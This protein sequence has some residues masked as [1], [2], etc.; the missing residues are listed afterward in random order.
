MQQLR[1][2]LEA[3]WE[4]ELAEYEHFKVLFQDSIDTLQK[5]LNE[6][7]DYTAPEVL[8]ID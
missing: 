4:Q 7:P 8:V 5:M 6:K 3:Q 2:D 1:A